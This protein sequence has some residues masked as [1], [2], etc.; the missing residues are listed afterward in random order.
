M[1]NTK[2]HTEQ[3]SPPNLFWTLSEGRSIFEFGAFLA[4][5]PALALSHRGDGHPVIVF[6]GFLASDRSTQPLRALLKGMGYAPYGWGLGRNM[7]YNEELEQAMLSLLDE[8][9]T[10]HGQ[11]VSLIGWSLG[12]TFAREIAK[13]KPDQVRCV[14]TMGSPISPNRD[15]MSPLTKAVSD[16]VSG[17]A[18]DVYAEKMAQLNVPPPTPTTSIYSKTDGI[19]GWR[20]A[21]QHPHPNNCQ[22]ENIAVPASHSG[23]GVNPLVVHIIADRLS[24][25]EGAWQPFDSNGAKKF[26]YRNAD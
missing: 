7:N 22:I 3:A 18:E 9:C 1:S 12:G 15:N 21:Y 5:F 10:R 2:T 25:A 20:G 19:V 8:V 14:I 17:P 16:R 26:F 4:A 24:Q 6:P 13:A 23:Y 11:S